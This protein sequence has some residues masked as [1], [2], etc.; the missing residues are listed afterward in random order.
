[1]ERKR[2]PFVRSLSGGRILSASQLPWFTVLPPRGFGVLTTIGRRTGKPRRKCV[3]AI[4]DGNRAYVVSIG[5]GRAAWM[6][7]GWSDPNVRL[8]IRGGS[9][10]GVARELTDPAAREK[11]SRIYCGTVNP[12]DY[13]ECTMHRAGR[14][15]RSKIQELHRHWFENGR[16]LVIDL[17]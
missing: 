16:A 6:K 7:S 12:F 8:R 4:R 1:M 14:P 3:R 5:G 10:A 15:T 17:G 9:F 13:V 2:N 11:A